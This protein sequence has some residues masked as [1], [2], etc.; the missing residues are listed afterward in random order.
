MSVT[1]A[2]SLSVIIPLYNERESVGKLHTE[3][4]SVLRELPLNRY[5]IIY[6]DDG[7]SDGTWEVCSDLAASD[8]EH[9][10]AVRL[11]RN[12]GQTAAMAAG[13]DLA[14]GD[15][16]A[17]MDGDLQ[18]DPADLGRLLDKLGEGFDVVSG[19]RRERMDS[20]LRRIPSRAA[21]CIISRVTGLRLHDYGCTMKVYR[22]ELLESVTM[23]GEMHRFLPA[24][25][26]WAGAR[27]SEIEVR[28][29]PRLHGVSKYGIDRTLRVILD[30]ITIKF[31]LSYSTRP[32]QIFGKWG[33][34]S[35]LLGFCA[36]AAS[37][38]LKIL[39]PHQDITN[40]PWIYMAIFLSLSG[41]QLVTMGLLGEI[42]I[43][44][45]YESQ[46]RKTYNVQEILGR[47]AR[48]GGAG[49]DEDTGA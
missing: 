26:A 10:T 38:A 45:W 1:S 11:R 22:R 42:N 16:V 14:G 12:F 23:Y 34:L 28:H 35:L 17:P 15:I 30:L 6:V 37:L 2:P 39:P 9:V 43:R 36:F 44:T 40:N 21:N 18:N 32:M 49:S 20:A 13:F 24:L 47:R 46:G 29:R 48:A 3:L 8:P 27:V 7:G 4:I 25:A 19:W 5:E 41:L 33:L 31:L